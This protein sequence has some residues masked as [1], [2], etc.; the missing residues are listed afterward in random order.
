M[1]FHRQGRLLSI[2]FSQPFFLGYV[3]WWSPRPAG[4]QGHILLFKYHQ[5]CTYQN[6]FNVLVRFFIILRVYGIW[7]QMR[8]TVRYDLSC[9]FIDAII[10]NCSDTPSLQNWKANPLISNVENRRHNWKD[11][12]TMFIFY[13]RMATLCLTP[14]CFICLVYREFNG[15]GKGPLGRGLAHISAMDIQEQ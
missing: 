12:T 11:T 8:E 9:S 13:G 6:P 10:G 5:R 3:S 7:N 2:A 14:A 1:Q 4:L 15:K